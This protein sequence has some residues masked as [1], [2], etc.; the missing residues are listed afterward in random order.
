[1][2]AKKLSVEQM[3]EAVTALD[4][5]NSI[6][7]AAEYLEIPRTTLSSRL[8]AAKANG[9][10][11][12]KSAVPYSVS[13]LPENDIPV[14]D[15]VDSLTTR[16]KKRKDHIE[17]KKW[18]QIKMRSS[19]PIGL[20]WMGDPHVDDNYCDWETLRHHVDII[21]SNS[22]IFACGLGDY[23]NNW[24]GRLSRLYAEQDTSHETAWKLVEWL[25][26]SINPLILIGGNHDMWSGSGDPLKWMAEAHTVHEDWEAKIEIKFPNGQSCF[27][28]AAHD[29][30][31]HSQWNPLHAQQKMAMFKS[32]AH[33]YIAGH[34][35]NWA[36]ANI[37]LVEQGM[38]TW[39]ARARGY[40]YWD[41]YALVK[42]FDNQ[43]FGHA[44]LQV[45]DPSATRPTGFTQCFVDVDAGAEYLRYLTQK[46]ESE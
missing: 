8:M 13:P 28:H 11:S 7:E 43:R 14:E 4:Q 37:E 44:I 31:G 34:R 17:S 18:R 26:K 40:K 10:T 45:I 2:A 46:Y 9:I 32:N 27:I 35:H 30:P 21:Q 42:G 25:I 29:M 41:T 19:A 33:L 16:F 24:V 6:V 23:Q 3:V 12:S 38:T 39:L 5:F 1:M 36:L 20:L 15:I 22:N